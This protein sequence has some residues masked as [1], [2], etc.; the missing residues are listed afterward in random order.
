MRYFNTFFKI[1][2]LFRDNVDY[3]ITSFNLIKLIMKDIY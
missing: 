1:D 2:I 3:F